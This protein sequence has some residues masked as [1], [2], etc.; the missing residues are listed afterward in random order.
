M[1]GLAPRR[2]RERGAA[3]LV[4]MVMIFV[5]SILGVSA[6][7][8]ATLESRLADNALHKEMTFQAAESATDAVLAVGGA[9]EDII[10]ASDV[11]MAVPEVNQ[12]AAQVTRATLSYGGR[13]NPPGYSLDRFAGR[14]F[15]VVGESALPGASTA[16]RIAQGVEL[17]GAVGPAGGC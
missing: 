1:D 10:C 6:M 8:G 11:E 3:L 17:I 13:T 9:L 5:L 15:M 7:R 14:R 16:T 2:N 12:V 4:A